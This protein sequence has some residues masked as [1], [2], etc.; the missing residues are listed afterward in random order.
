MMEQTFYKY[1]GTGNDFVMIDNRQQT[2]NKKDTKRVAFLCD[3][4]FGVGADGLILLENHPE[5]AGQAVY[6]DPR[7][8]D[9]TFKPTLEGMQ[10]L[11]DQGVRILAPPMPMLLTLEDDE[12]TPSDYA[13]YAKAMVEANNRYGHVGPIPYLNHKDKYHINIDDF[14]DF[15]MAELLIKKG[16]VN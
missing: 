10:A 13:V 2:F 11:Y 12:L 9:R 1:Q 6:L 8:R 15:W 14:T 16:E 7:G 5:Y 4:R 3:R